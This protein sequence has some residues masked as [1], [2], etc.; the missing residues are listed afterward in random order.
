VKQVAAGCGGDLFHL[1]R[2]V[3]D[4]AARGVLGRSALVDHLAA[5]VDNGRLS[6]QSAGQALLLGD[7]RSS[8]DL[9]M[10]TAP[11]YRAGR[12]DQAAQLEAALFEHVF[13]RLESVVEGIY[14][15]VRDLYVELGPDLTGAGLAAWAGR[16]LDPL[17]EALRERGLEVDLTF[18]H[19]EK[20]VGTHA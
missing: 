17:L 13:P 11:F 12:P 16:V 20:E 3:V 18:Y 9:A 15:V 19:S 10:E 8:L 2:L 6:R 5:D 14:R 7:L 4:A 1:D